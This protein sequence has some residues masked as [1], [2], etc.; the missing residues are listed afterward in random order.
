[1]DITVRELRAVLALLLPIV[2]KRSTLPITQNILVKDGQAM[3]T[4]LEAWGSVRLDPAET[5]AMLLSPRMLEAL[6]H[7]PADRILKV[8]ALQAG[9]TTVEGGGMTSSWD[10]GAPKDFPPFPD[11]LGPAGARATLSGDRFVEALVAVAECAAIDNSRPILTGILVHATEEGMTVVGAD[12]FRLCYQP[13]PMRLGEPGMRFIIPGATVK[14]LARLWHQ[15]AER[16]VSGI[17]SVADLARD[18]KPMRVTVG[19]PQHLIRFAFGRVTLVS[20]LI[21]GT[22]PDYESLIPKSHGEPVTFQAEALY[23]AVGLVHEMANNGIIRLQ[24]D[25]SGVISVSA[26]GEDVGTARVEV[27]GATRG[28]GFIA[29]NDRYLHPALKGLSGEVTLLTTTPSA[30]AVLRRWGAPDLILMPMFVAPPTAATPAAEP[31]KEQ[32]EEGPQEAPEPPA[33]PEDGASPEDSAASP[34][35]TPAPAAEA[36]ATRRGRRKKA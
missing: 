28:S 2:A 20:Q 5:E 19:E 22:F 27:L 24:W 33:V 13:T 14:K 4:D 9:S 7:M 12:G 32:P 25:P 18:T 8:L 11:A 10:V 21:A 35:E 26:T 34:P 15:A 23:A 16:D 3:A 1:M 6:S 29:F 30:P 36:K 31:P 17:E